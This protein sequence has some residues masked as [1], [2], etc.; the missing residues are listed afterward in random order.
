MQLQNFLSIDGLITGIVAFAFGFIVLARNKKSIVNQTLFLLTTTTAL[1]SLGYWYWL[2]IY[3]DGESALFWT[4][5][6]SIGSTLIPL[7]YFHWVVSLLGLNKQKKIKILIF[8]I[9][10]FLFLLFSFSPLFV[11]G[12]EPSSH[13]AFWPKAGWLYSLYL[14]SIYFY[15]VIYSVILLLKNYRDSVGLKRTQ[16]KY[17]LLGS[18]LGFGG[19]AT[20]FFL[21]Y[22]INILPLG[23]VLV[24]LY[25][26]LF[27]Y[28]II[29]HRLMDIKFVLRKSY[30]YLASF[31]VIVVISILLKYTL[32]RYFQDIS[33]QM[34]FVILVL[35]ILV[36]SPIKSYFYRIGNKYF[37]SSLY[38]S[39][40]VIANITDKLRSTLEVKIIYDFICKNLNS[41]LHFKS[42]AILS[43]SEKQNC[44]VLQYNQGFNLEKQKK[45]LENK[46]LQE[47]F[48]DKSEAII[49]EEIKHSFYN[50]KTKEV[51][52]L[53]EG[54]NVDILIPLNVKDK[55]IGLM[56][57]GAKESGDMYNDEDLKVLKI[58][59]GQA[60]MA[61]ENALL[62]G[63][64]LNFN[65]KLKKEIEKATEELT[66][67]NVEL[68]KL[69]EAKSNFVSIASHQLRTPLT[70]I[71]GYVS[72]MLEGSF[73]KLNP[74]ERDSLEKV[75]ASGERLIQLVENLLNISR[76]ESGRLQF[77]YEEVQLEDMIGGVVEE[78]SGYA[79]KRGLKLEYK[80]P[81]KA[82]PK[83]N[84]DEEK[85]RQVAMNLI[86]NSIKYTKKGS[87]TVSLKKIGQIIRFC[88]S[89]SG[90]GID[91]EDLPNLFKKFSRGKGTSVVHTEGTGLGLYVAKEMVD[92]HNG[93][94]WAESKGKDKG[95]KFCFELPIKTG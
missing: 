53:L 91:K 58:V 20:N 39:Q 62:Y 54:F 26:I 36:F 27:S 80:K 83:L 55:I 67:A 49:V 66:L 50:E 77:N 89:D 1:W 24:V 22:D 71:K 82:F 37:F 5:V 25:P 19:G 17:V 23:N 95:S 8:Y 14:V 21:W 86:D 84:I 69:D 51:I 32:D 65:I 72:M 81:E 13:F 31:S 94:I 11:K 47:I 85:I 41:A 18:I 76:I 75:Y 61:I 40:E 10:T 9:L 59:S 12:V 73:G 64:T 6:L 29:K 15:L 4:R 57:L 16:I 45:F 63:E 88:V 30:V 34:D 74:G 93:K 33:T 48:T 42:F 46:E 2:S 70:V 60:A 92:A 28:S 87:V 52:D 7:F 35:S 79:K 3:Q 68:K 38:D 43:Y 56:V 78:L 90:M 44:Y